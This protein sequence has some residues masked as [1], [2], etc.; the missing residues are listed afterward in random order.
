V[1]RVRPVPAAAPPPP[2][3]GAAPGGKSAPG[4]DGAFHVQIG[5]FKSQGEAER[6]LAS[7]VRRAQAPQ[8]RLPGDEGRVAGVGPSG[9]D[10]VPQ[11]AFHPVDRLL[12]IDSPARVDRRRVTGARPPPSHLLRGAVGQ[13]HTRA[14]IGGLDDHGALAD[15]MPQGLTERIASDL[16]QWLGHCQE[17][18]RG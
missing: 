8:R 4:P 5:A 11:P 6:Q 1:L 17:I 10:T 14:P 15:L 18:F 12:R 16:E 13:E 9:S 7:V 3:A 2:K